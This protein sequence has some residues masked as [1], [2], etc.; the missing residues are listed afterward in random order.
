MFSN[1]NPKNLILAGSNPVYHNFQVKLAIKFNVFRKMQKKI[2]LIHVDHIFIGNRFLI[3]DHT[4]FISF[5]LRYL[6]LIDR[7][8]LSWTKAFG[9]TFNCCLKLQARKLAEYYFL[10]NENPSRDCESKT[11]FSEFELFVHWK[12]TA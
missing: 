11:G 1:F 9:L 2:L 5:A 8:W 7:Y 6:P 12:S 3:F 10:S 4:C